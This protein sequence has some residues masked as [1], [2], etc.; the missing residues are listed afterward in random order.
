MWYGYG[1]T[2]QF[3]HADVDDMSEHQKTLCF[4][5]QNA[6]VHDHGFHLATHSLATCALNVTTTSSSSSSESSPSSSYHHQYISLMEMLQAKTTVRELASR[7]VLPHQSTNHFFVH[8]AYVIPP[9]SL[10]ADKQRGHSLKL[11]KPLKIG[12][13]NISSNHQFSWAMLVSG[14][15]NFSYLF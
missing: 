14:R 4:V 5:G 1:K 15:E 11:A 3:A 6:H 7:T 2:P 8:L 9:D 13:P 12:I 10:K